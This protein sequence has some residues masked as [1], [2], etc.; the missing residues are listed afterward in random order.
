M[1]AT[2]CSNCMSTI[3]G[4]AIYMSAASNAVKETFIGKSHHLNAIRYK[5]LSARKAHQPGYCIRHV[6]R[7]WVCSLLL[8]Q[9]L[10]AHPVFLHSNCYATKMPWQ[11]RLTN[12]STLRSLSVLLETDYWS[13][14]K[15]YWFGSNRE[16]GRA[17][18]IPSG[19]VNTVGSAV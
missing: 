7:D 11:L 17:R 19:A 12:M 8:L 3:V 18:L 10:P 16:V 6:D 15:W 14:Y 9:Y 2:V 13:S 1:G 5:C 4:N